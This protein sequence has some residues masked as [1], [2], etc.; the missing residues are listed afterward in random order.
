LLTDDVTEEQ[1]G[2]ELPSVR[3][4]LVYEGSRLVAVLPGRADSDGP[5]AVGAT[6][7][8]VATVA[9]GA[10][11]VARLPARPPVSGAPIEF[12]RFLPDGSLVALHD[13]GVLARLDR[14][15]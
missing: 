8:L 14:A 9:D 10:V 6:G 2:A 11:R 15:G 3:R 12:A 1:V 7:D 13:D 4:L 5:Y